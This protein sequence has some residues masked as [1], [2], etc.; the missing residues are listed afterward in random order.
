MRLPQQN[1]QVPR[2]RGPLAFQGIASESEFRDYQGDSESS[3]S[4]R[5]ILATSTNAHRPTAT[6]RQ[7]TSTAVQPLPISKTRQTS[8]RQT[9]SITANDESSPFHRNFL[10]QRSSGLGT[11]AFLGSS[12]NSQPH[13][14]HQLNS[15]PKAQNNLERSDYPLL[16]ASAV[17]VSSITSN[18]A[19]SPYG[20]ITSHTTSSFRAD[21]SSSL[22]SGRFNS[23][24]NKFPY[25]FHPTAATM[26]VP[27][28]TRSSA[29]VSSVPIDTP[30]GIKLE[31][32]GDASDTDISNLTTETS[33]FPTAER[34]H[35]RIGSLIARFSKRLTADD[36]AENQEIKTETPSLL[37]S[38][39]SVPAVQDHP[40]DKE[41][42]TMP[43]VNPTPSSA[44]LQGNKTAHKNEVVSTTKRLAPAAFGLSSPQ[45]QHSVAIRSCFRTMDT[46]SCASHASVASGFQSEG[47]GFQSET[48]WV[49]KNTSGMNENTIAGGASD[50]EACGS[51]VHNLPLRTIPLPPLSLLPSSGGDGCLN[52]KLSNG[53]HGED[54]RKRKRHAKR[55][56]YQE[57][58]GLIIGLLVA[59]FLFGVITLVVCYILSQRNANPNIVE[60]GM[61]NVNDAATFSGSAHINDD[62]KWNYP[63][64]VGTNGTL[65][66]TE[67]LSPTKIPSEN[68]A[69][70]IEEVLTHAEP[71]GSLTLLPTIVAA[72]SSPSL[73]SSTLA[74][75]LTTPT[76]GTTE[77]TQALDASLS[78]A[79]SNAPTALGIPPAEALSSFLYPD[80]ILQQES[81]MW[82]TGEGDAA[83][84]SLALSK[85][86]Q[87]LIFGAP[88]GD[89]INAA[90][91]RVGHV[92]VYERSRRTEVIVSRDTGDAWEWTLRALIQGDEG[93]SQ[94]GFSVAIDD[95][96]ST[97]VVSQPTF[98]SRRGKVTIYEWQPRSDGESGGE[99]V[100]RHVLVGDQTAD[101]FGISVSLSADGKRLAVSSPYYSSQAQPDQPALLLRGQVHVFEYSEAI[102]EYQPMKAEGGSYLLGSNSLDWFGWSVSLS[103]DGMTLAAGAPRN[104]EFG[105]YVQCFRYD[106]DRW[107][108]LGGPIVNDV[109][110]V[111]LDDRFGHAI[112]V[113]TTGTT[114]SGNGF[115]TRLSIGAPWKDVG[116]VLN[117]GMVA[118]YEWSPSES[119]WLQ[120][121][122]GALGGIL[123]E[124]E[125]GF[126]HQLGYSMHMDGD[127]IAVG[128]PGWKNRRGLVNIFWLSHAFSDNNSGTWERLT[129]P[130]MGESDGDDFGFSVSLTLKMKDAEVKEPAA[131]FVAAGAIMVSAPSPVSTG[132]SKVF[133]LGDS[134]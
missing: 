87:V 6:T 114:P 34:D 100:P 131:V 67:D 13:S 79:Q 92:H 116:D 11:T 106:G 20:A 61:D 42:S 64:G 97:I 40:I 33:D 41:M 132:Y 51:S 54:Q 78:A 24:S 3:A 84:S 47:T 62:D 105:G 48:T 52:T 93:L 69:D 130:L 25:S 127:A 31:A 39:S 85:N 95:D 45:S 83:G 77:T 23:T 57:T 120:D 103:S 16:Q 113:T 104:T 80:V 129:N 121:T 29:R 90:I 110:P 17:D 68:E 26:V 28:A 109:M 112:S 118:I 49:I 111:K 30:R 15:F 10:P 22:E 73:D 55:K 81:Q 76:S 53:T 27:H 98:D 124:D 74:P 4:V 44:V 134:L 1:Q 101:H 46:F 32:A 122:G 38:V 66:M 43:H 99:Y 50:V 9:P 18:S 5:R 35:G 75:T 94:L 8:T 88:N 56:M 59:L 115:V 7:A 63:D 71:T 133:Q 70:A 82:G 117:S 36:T 128:I 107:V 65:S 126:Y 86:G 89:N 58:Q 102:Q 108:A 119:S 60:D 72:P 21:S 2:P 125:P 91:E 37:V 96:G 14:H 19:A 123:T 12:H